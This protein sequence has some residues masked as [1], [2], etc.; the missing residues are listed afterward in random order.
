MEQN[1][2]TLDRM[3]RLSLLYDFYGVLLKEQKRKI[4]EDYIQND[5]SLGEIARMCNISRQGVHDL[6][7]RCIKELED[8]EEKL[9]LISRFQSTKEKVLRIK[10]NA[11]DIK[12]TV[13][14][15]SPKQENDKRVLDHIEDICRM[16]DEIA[17][18][19]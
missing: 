6:V 7:K 3:V 19:L 18:A 2:D 4:F 1:T 14:A 11:A 5:Y 12:D 15:G 8:Y 13:A 16:A 17:E 10:E 9:C